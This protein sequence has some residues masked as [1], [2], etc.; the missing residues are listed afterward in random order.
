MKLDSSFEV[1]S[2]RFYWGPIGKLCA[3][4]EMFVLVSA[5][6]WG[7]V[8]S[9]SVSSYEFPLTSAL[10][11]SFTFIPLPVAN[12]CVQG[13]LLHVPLC[14]LGSLSS[15]HAVPTIPLRCG[16]FLHST[17]W[18]NPGDCP[19]ASAGS[20]VFIQVRGQ[21]CVL[22]RGDSRRVFPVLCLLLSPFPVSLAVTPSDCS[23]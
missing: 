3:S 9:S 18:R 17:E 21:C 15:V 23:W 16:S 1:R 4:S 12:P 10:P 11:R 8:E 19:E 22:L 2:P 5:S 14:M 20:R 13:S 7:E 6:C